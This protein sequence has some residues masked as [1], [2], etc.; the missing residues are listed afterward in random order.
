MKVLHI[1]RRFHPLTGGTER[2]VAEI[3]RRLSARGVDSRVLTL[4]RDVL[5]RGVLPDTGRHGAVEIHR[6]PHIGGHKKPLPLKI[7]LSLFQWADVVHSHDPRLFYETTLVLKPFLRYKV[8]FS[9]HGFLLHTSDV[10]LLKNVMIPLYYLPTLR[11]MVD[12]VIAVSE[13]DHQY[14]A[15]HGI[16]R[17]HLITNGVDVARFGSSTRRPVK[18][19][20]LYFG[21]VDQ[22]KG[23]GL[24]LKALARI[25]H[26]DWELHIV[27]GGPKATQTRLQAMGR[28][29]GID[30]RLR[31][32]GF[33]VEAEILNHLAKS[34][35]CLFPS[36]YEG[37]G[38]A[39]IEAM[40]AGCVCVVNDITAYR[41]IV[42]KN[43][44]AI[45]CDFD[46]TDQTADR[47]AQLVETSPDEL[48]DL[49]RSARETA[50]SYDWSTR[51]DQLL[52]IYES[53]T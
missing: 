28:E 20:L 43:R 48:A 34:H 52:A 31:W 50:R 51:V 44:D 7:P 47:L 12:A 33:V 8:V 35:L 2:H 17:L 15:N 41:Q 46:R 36:T 19:R 45:I 24:L 25:Q 9:T 11:H 39:L 37:F 4:K 29:F 3:T 27:G 49:G 18:G 38:L 23:I 21:R 40:A 10:Q 22:N 13:N 26:A 14:F 32:H 1:S 53:L 6:V 42:T 5:G 30:G 16:D